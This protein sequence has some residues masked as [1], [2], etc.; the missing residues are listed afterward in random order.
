[1]GSTEQM[2]FCSDKEE[3]RKRLQ[4]HLERCF[5]SVQAAFLEADHD[6]DGFV[7]LADFRSMLEAYNLSIE[8]IDFLLPVTRHERNQDINLPIHEFIALITGEMCSS[9]NEFLWHS[10]VGQG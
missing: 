4:R 1:M 6:K 10:P 9:T 8:E 2:T 7:N 5:G 3:L